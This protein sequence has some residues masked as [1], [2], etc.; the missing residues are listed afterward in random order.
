VELDLSRQVPGSRGFQGQ[1]VDAD[2]TDVLTTMLALA[3]GR[4]TEA[5]LA[6]WL[7]SHLVAMT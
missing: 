2:E 1:D 3:A 5:E 6:S 7:R 4:L